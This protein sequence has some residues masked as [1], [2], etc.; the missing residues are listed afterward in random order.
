[1]SDL[2]FIQSSPKKEYTGI[3]TIR[4]LT[5][6]QILS[7]EHEENST[8]VYVDNKELTTLKV[9]GWVSNTKSTNNGKSFLLEDGTGNI[10]CMMWCNKS[11]EEYLLSLVEDGL[12]VKV[13]GILKEYG[14]KKSI[15]ISNIYLVKDFNEFTYHMSSVIQEHFINNK[16]EVKQSKEMKK[17]HNDL[18]ECIRNNQDEESGLD[19]KIVIK[20]LQN[21]YNER[22]IKE[23]LDFLVDNCYLIVTD[24]NGYK[25]VN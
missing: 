13:V 8:V 14:N 17:I 18:L 15:Q 19:L 11:Y 22:M 7:S 25:C 23:N 10:E 3:K 4:S 9:L 16:K 1:M 5:I 12:L 21:E 2:G 6:K 20:C 24:E